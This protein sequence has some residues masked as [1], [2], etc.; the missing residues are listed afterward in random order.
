MKY[1]IEELDAMEGHDF[2]HAVADLLRHNGYREVRATQASGDYGIDIL[3]RRKNVRYAIQCKRWKALC[4]G[5]ENFVLKGLS[6]TAIGLMRYSEA[7]S[8]M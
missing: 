6:I 1:T 4:L 2:E 3:A 5:T 8:F 7:N